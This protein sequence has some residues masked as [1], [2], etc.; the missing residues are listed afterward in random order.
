MVGPRKKK[1]P[2]KLV[3]TDCDSTISKELGGT[4]RFPKKWVNHYC[5]HK[6]LD[7]EVAFIKKFPFTPKWCPAMNKITEQACRSD[8]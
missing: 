5:T 6:A 7:T 1:M 2:D 4:K 3:C 8:A